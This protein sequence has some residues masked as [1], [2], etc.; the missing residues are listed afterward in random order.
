MLTCYFS[1]I[2]QDQDREGAP[3]CLLQRQDEP[4][5]NYALYGSTGDCT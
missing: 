4:Q 3:Q 1:A 2:E 5:G